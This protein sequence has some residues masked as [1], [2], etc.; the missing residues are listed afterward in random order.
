MRFFLKFHVLR[1]GCR[2]EFMKHVAGLLD[3]D[4]IL[5]LDEIPQHFKYTRLRHSMDV[6]YISFYIARILKCDSRSAAR[7]GMLHDLFFH[8]EGQNSRSLLLSHPK[9][10]LE[11]A[12]SIVD[13]LNLREEDAIL[14][15]MWFL[16]LTPPRYAEGMIITFVDKFCAGREFIISLFH[17]KGQISCRS[18]YVFDNITE[19][20]KLTAFAAD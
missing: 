14:R 11:N 19:Q 9:I 1:E 13:D 2:T 12:R 3:N 20:A 7:A 15:H 6:A 5:A 18:K 10:A 8:E 17:G 4:L 16:T